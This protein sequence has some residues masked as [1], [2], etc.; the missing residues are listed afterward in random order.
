MLSRLP[1]PQPSSPK[2]SPSASPPLVSSPKISELHEL[3]SPRHLESPQVP[4]KAE[5]VASP[6]LT[7]ISLSNLKPVSN[8]S[9]VASHSSPIRVDAG[10]S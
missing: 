10:G 9:E 6:P 7:P 3:P 8:V 5:E 2:V 1:N 4:G